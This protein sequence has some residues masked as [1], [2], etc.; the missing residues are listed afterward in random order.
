MRFLTDVVMGLVLAG[1]ALV[2]IAAAI[3]TF[4]AHPNRDSAGPGALAGGCA[5]AFAILMHGVM[6]RQP[7][8]EATDKGSGQQ[9]DE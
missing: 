8:E 6:A 2:T 1:L 7:A 4:E 9:P 5:V 3:C